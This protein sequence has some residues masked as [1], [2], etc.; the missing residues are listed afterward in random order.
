MC[1][2][3][4]LVVSIGSLSMAAVGSPIGVRGLPQDDSVTTARAAAIRRKS[5]HSLGNDEPVLFPAPDYS[6]SPPRSPGRTWEGGGA[7]DL[8]NSRE[9]VGGQLRTPWQ[10][11]RGTP[12]CSII[13]APAPGGQDCW[14]DC[15]IHPDPCEEDLLPPGQA[16]REGM[17][18]RGNECTRS[19][20]YAGLAHDE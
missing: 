6:S 8:G 16:R 14:G 15:G 17:W 11:S 20:P 1:F 19:D 13:G 10:S 4:C 7:E 9:C 12:G 2:R 5:S 18:A 3:R